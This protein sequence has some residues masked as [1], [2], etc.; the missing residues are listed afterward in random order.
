VTEKYAETILK[1]ED[2]TI[3]I[4]RPWNIKSKVKPIIIGAT[5]TT[6]KSHRKYLSNIPGNIR[7]QPYWALHTYFGNY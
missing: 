6:T 3:Q 1:Y 7:K 4:Q 5:G 2:L